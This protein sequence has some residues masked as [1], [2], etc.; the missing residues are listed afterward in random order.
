MGKRR[1]KEAGKGGRKNEVQEGE[2]GGEHS[3]GDSLPSPWSSTRPPQLPR[4]LHFILNPPVG[5]SIVEVTQWLWAQVMSQGLHQPFISL[6]K[7][8]Q[9]NK[10]RWLIHFTRL[11][12]TPFLS[13]KSR[14]QAQQLQQE[15]FHFIVR[16]TQLGHPEN[17]SHFITFYSARNIPFIVLSVRL[18]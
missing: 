13:L 2:Q 16:I 3:F 14:S 1:R 10:A 18:S 6:L 15:C 5:D 11:P 12:P 17:V 8:L 4:N 7:V 9:V